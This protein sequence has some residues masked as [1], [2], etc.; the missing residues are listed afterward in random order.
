MRQW[1]HA[2]AV[3]IFALLPAPLDALAEPPSRQSTTAFSNELL[4]RQ[5]QALLR[6]PNRIDVTYTT[7]GA[8]RDVF[9]KNGDT[10]FKLTGVENLAEG[11]PAPQVLRDL[12]DLLMAVGTE[13]FTVRTVFD[14]L[15]GLRT[16]ALTQS[17][18]GIPVVHGG[19]L[20]IE[21]HQAT[22]NIRGLSSHFLPDRGLAPAP[23]ILSSVA[24]ERAKT[25]VVAQKDSEENSADIVNDPAL[26]YYAGGPESDAA[27]LVW[28]VNITYLT[29]DGGP[30]SKEVFV[31]AVT[32]EVVFEA[33]LG[34]AH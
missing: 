3:L 25:Y 15:P 10:G 17:I 5:Y 26:V 34:S 8:V 4:D 9:A 31:N 23:L 21:F 20:A 29:R 32:G 24:A 27:A 1:T 12:S 18:R 6:I 19:G 7:R 14:S 13:Q 30:L 2:H 22:G 16:I 33:A 11:D 28:A